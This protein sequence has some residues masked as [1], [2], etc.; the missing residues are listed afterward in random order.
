MAFACAFRTAGVRPHLREFK[1]EIRENLTYAESCLSCSNA[2][3]TTS[4]QLAYDYAGL[5]DLQ[6]ALQTTGEII[7]EVDPDTVFKFIEV[8]EQLAQCIP[9]CRDLRQV[10]PSSFTA[11]LTSE[12][13]FMTLNFQVVVEV[14]KINPPHAIEA[15][16]MGRPIGFSGQ[17][18]GTAELRLAD[19]GQGRTV[20]RHSSDIGLTGKLGSLGQPVFRAKSAEMTAK[21]AANLKAA[22][23]RNAGQKKTAD[24]SQA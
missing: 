4:D 3:A 21:F 8:P 12:V 11:L 14:V 22:L 2:F 1:I 24:E 20:I 15:R 17:L 9:G 10:A 5:G 18:I 13:S 6:M 16:I 7:V 23:E 19:A